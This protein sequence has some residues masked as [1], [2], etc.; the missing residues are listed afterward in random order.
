MD[1]WQLLELLQ[2]TGKYK[3]KSK[4]LSQIS[5]TNALEHVGLEVPDGSP[6]LKTVDDFREYYWGGKA[7]DAVQASLMV[8]K[9]RACWME[10]RHVKYL[11]Q[12]FYKK[13]LAK[14]EKAEKE[15][16]GHYH[17]HGQGD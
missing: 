10:I 16:K 1:F 6:L 8:E 7:K 14:K 12:T 13:W 11:D 2:E 4:E 15:H 3:N 5:A 17:E 9:A